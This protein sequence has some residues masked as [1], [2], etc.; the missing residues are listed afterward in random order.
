MSRILTHSNVQSVALSLGSDSGSFANPKHEVPHNI[1]EMALCH[2]KYQEI[3]V[4][5]VTRYD[6]IIGL[7]GLDAC[8]ILSD[9]DLLPS[10]KTGKAK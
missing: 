2:A 7:R 4:Y 10:R 6:W 3:W 5:S 8:A 1:G 9:W